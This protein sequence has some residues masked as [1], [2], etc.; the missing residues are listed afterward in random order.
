MYA[1]TRNNFRSIAGGYRAADPCGRNAVPA[2]G[3]SA[4]SG[5]P[6]LQKRKRCVL[7]SLANVKE[8][9]EY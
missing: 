5:E 2:G 3:T 9:I 7:A 4:I 8:C 6:N 1:A